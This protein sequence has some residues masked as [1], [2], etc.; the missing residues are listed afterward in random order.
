M[1]TYLKNGKGDPGHL[2]K[3]AL[4][5]RQLRRYAHLTLAAAGRKMGVGRERTRYLYR[6]YGIKRKK[7]PRRPAG[8]I[9]FV[10]QL[11][12]PGFHAGRVV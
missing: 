8:R 2:R 9:K 10:Q 6:I 12:Q 3:P 5:T 11:R 1:A 7:A 4:R